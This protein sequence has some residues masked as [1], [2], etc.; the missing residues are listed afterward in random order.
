[1]HGHSAIVLRLIEINTMTW[2]RDIIA[3]ELVQ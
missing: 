2:R 1:M 3:I